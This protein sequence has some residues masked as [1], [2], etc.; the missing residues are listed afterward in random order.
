LNNDGGGMIMMA[1]LRKHHKDQSVNVQVFKPLLAASTKP[2]NTPYSKVK[3][4]P[5]Q[6]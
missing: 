1:V 6:A 5:L 2:N 3:P 4:L